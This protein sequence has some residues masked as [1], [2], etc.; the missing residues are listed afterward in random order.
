MKIPNHCWASCLLAYLP[1]SSFDFYSLYITNALHRDIN[2]LEDR[3]WIFSFWVLW[4]EAEASPS[5]WQLCNCDRT[6]TGA[7]SNGCCWWENETAL[8]VPVIRASS[9]VFLQRQAFVNLIEVYLITKALKG[10]TCVKF[11]LCLCNMV[12][13]SDINQLLCGECIWIPFPWLFAGVIIIFCDFSL[14]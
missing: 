12:I 10:L 8:C 11:T 7:L 4:P 6:N 3:A 5:L 9:V 2:Q 14:T 1:S 13:K